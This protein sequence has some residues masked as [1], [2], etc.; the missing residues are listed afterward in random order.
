MIDTNWAIYY[1]SPQFDISRFQDP[2][3][4]ISE[5][6]DMGFKVMVWVTP[7]ISPDSTVFRLAR[8]KKYLVKNHWCGGGCLPLWTY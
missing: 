2:A 5:L 3:S 8:R 7:F 6:H 4:M 1:G